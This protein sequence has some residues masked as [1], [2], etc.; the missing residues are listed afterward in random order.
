MG[1]EVTW[2]KPERV[3]FANYIGYQTVETITAC[4]D[5]MVGA[6]DTVSR[7]VMVLINWKEVTGMDMKALMQVRGHRAYSHPMA[8]R[9]VLVGMPRQAQFENEVTAVSTRDITNTQYYNTMEDALDY[10][11][12]FLAD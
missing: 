11:K 8:A 2:L 1:H 6:L 5:E 7:P 12:N 10:L 4:L 9:G 3:L